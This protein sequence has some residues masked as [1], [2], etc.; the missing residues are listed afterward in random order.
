MLLAE[1]AEQMAVI[2]KPNMMEQV[3]ANMAKRG[4]V[5]ID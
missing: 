5:F 2:G 1:T 3:A 4:A